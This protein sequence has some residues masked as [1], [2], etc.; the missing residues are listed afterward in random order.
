MMAG[1]L[2]EPMPFSREIPAFAGR[3]AR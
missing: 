3:I 2:V 1:P